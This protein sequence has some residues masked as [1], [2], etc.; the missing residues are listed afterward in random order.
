M[1]RGW[2]GLNDYK[3]S[4]FISRMFSSQDVT[5]VD[6]LGSPRDLCKW[7]HPIKAVSEKFACADQGYFQAKVHEH[8]DTSTADDPSFF[9]TETY[10][11]VW[12]VINLFLEIEKSVCDNIYVYVLF[13]T[14]L[15]SN[16]LSKNKLKYISIQVFHVKTKA[17]R[18][19]DPPIANWTD[20]FP[21]KLFP[22]L[23]L[24]F[25]SFG[26]RFNMWLSLKLFN[27]FDLA[28]KL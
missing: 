6:P 11:I 2:E 9:L 15:I 20:L 5:T 18:K 16:L 24:F 4:S 21:W 27:C 3:G 8:A 19:A 25:N 22:H 7:S 13:E 17:S 10:K 26:C 14:I 1:Y 12:R 28:F 23:L